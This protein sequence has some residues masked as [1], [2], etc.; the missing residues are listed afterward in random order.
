ME[1]EPSNRNLMWLVVAA[2]AA[3]GLL[4]ALGAFLG[5][6][7]ATPDYDWRRMGVAL[8][9]I[10]GFLGIWMGALWAKRRR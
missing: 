7:P 1:R 8:A 3:W 9:A 5:L 2:L 4:L 6:D 10:G